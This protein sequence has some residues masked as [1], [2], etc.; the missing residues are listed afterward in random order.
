MELVALGAEWHSK[1]SYL[2]QPVSLTLRF[3][4]KKNNQDSPVNHSTIAPYSGCDV[5][6]AIG[7][8]IRAE[9]KIIVGGFTYLLCT[10]G[11]C[12]IRD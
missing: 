1:V 8:I 12:R 6:S 9:N 2:Y 7:A 5:L 3:K 4:K 10:L 11:K